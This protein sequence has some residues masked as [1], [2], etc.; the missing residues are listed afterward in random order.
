MVAVSEGVADDL[1]EL[2]KVERER[3]TVVPNGFSPEQCSPERRRTLRPEWR[4]RLSLAE[5]DVALLM[6]ANE[7]H[8]KGLGAV[9]EAMKLS[10]DPRLKLV[11][12]GRQE[13]TTYQS[14]MRRL[15]LR[16]RVSWY[17]PAEDVAL[18]H[19][20]ADL[21]VLP[22][23]YEP[24]GTVIVEALA[25]GVPVI[26]SKLAGASIAVVPEKNGLLLERPHDPTELAGVLSRALEPGVLAAWSEASP[27]S[28][29]GYSWRAVMGRLETL[30]VDAVC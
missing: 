24:F 8:R 3:I 1:V 25:S 9:L 12:V 26:T 18:Y 11:L 19:A 2:Y 21:F 6:V 30:L 4:E 16:A 10:A 23:L 20:A 15:G 7:W 28:V 27:P 13:P 29:S 5:D 17:G 22:T 14:Q